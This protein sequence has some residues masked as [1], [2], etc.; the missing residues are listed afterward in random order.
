MVQVWI[1]SRS[2]LRT[3]EVL[4]TYVDTVKQSE[5]HESVEEVAGGASNLASLKI[6]TLGW[7]RCCPK[8]PAD[9]CRWRPRMLGRWGQDCFRKRGFSSLQ[10]RQVL[11]CGA[12]ANNK[13]IKINGT[14][15]ER[16]GVGE[17]AR[18]LRGGAAPTGCAWTCAC[19]M[20][21]DYL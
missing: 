4:P 13:G 20:T 8:S 2:Q 7:C 17:E 16:T 12:V 3:K 6:N 14:Q 19:K 18:C 11:T 1:M 10:L 21:H 9:G 5:R 15:I